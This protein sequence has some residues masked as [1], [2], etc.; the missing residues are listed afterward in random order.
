[1]PHW[2]APRPIVSVQLMVRL[3]NE[4]G[5]AA[6]RC[7]AGTRITP[8]QLE[9][10]LSEIRGNQELGVLRNVLHA[11]GP[12]VPFA[13]KAGLRYHLTTHGAWGFV[14][15][16]CCSAREAIALSFRY[17]DLCYS[18]NQVKLE[19]E[20]DVAHLVYDG[21]ANP[22]DLQA[23]LIERDLGALLTF[24]SDILGRRLPALALTLRGP[25][26]AYAREFEPLFGV[27]PRFAAERSR[28]SFD[29]SYLEIRNPLA[30]GFGLRVSE[31][32][33]HSHL[34]QRAA[35]SGVAGRVRREIVRKPGE[36]P[37]M[38]EVAARLGV[39]RRTL[40]NQLAQEGCSYRELVE[41][42]REALAEDLL[43]STRASLD[44]IAVRLGYSD[45]SSFVA[46]FKRWKGAPPGEYRRSLSAPERHSAPRVR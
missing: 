29:A 27:E 7:L 41:Q 16:S 2:E 37:S 43:A 32:Q 35:R 17:W 24:E 44:E 31:N 15:L 38:Q 36:F 22:D 26:P 1:M 18:F 20:G 11:L 3:A 14:Q 21:S 46:A 12:D 13:L 34:E 4:Y 19:V 9:D 6:E 28:L 8:E 25:R 10:P 40:H 39:S 33:C 45:T 42:L 5:L 30:D 23:A